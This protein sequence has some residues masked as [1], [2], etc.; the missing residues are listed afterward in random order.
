MLG[1]Y[2][3]TTGMSRGKEKLV[4]VSPSASAEITEAA[5]RLPVL[6]KLFRSSLWA[7]GAPVVAVFASPVPIPGWQRGS[8]QQT[9]PHSLVVMRWVTMQQGIMIEMMTVHEH[10]Q[11]KDRFGL[12]E[13][14]LADMRR[15]R[16]GCF[17]D[18]GPCA[19]VRTPFTPPFWYYDRNPKLWVSYSTGSFYDFGMGWQ[20]R[21]DTPDL[22]LP[23]GDPTAAFTSRQTGI[24]KGRMSW[25]EPKPELVR[26]GEGLLLEF[27]AGTLKLL[28]SLGQHMT[29]PLEALPRSLRR[30]AQRNERARAARRKPPEARPFLVVDV[31][32]VP[33]FS[34]VPSRS[35][36]GAERTLGVRHWV[37]GHWRKLPRRGA[38]DSDTGVNDSD[39]RTDEDDAEY[40]WVRPHVR[41]DPSLPWAKKRQTVYRVKQRGG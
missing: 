24:R 10:E 13:T 11:I 38:P 25:P 3:Q 26:D 32:S 5:E 17:G 41:G 23:S 4:W 7:D 1:S 40:T 29:V 6:P 39:D 19:P 35:S 8:G 30:Q 15:R 34:S 18:D 27:E 21:E 22:R 20:T 14:D 28:Y 37:R 33:A 12:T 16:F 36:G 2:N 9:K 31:P